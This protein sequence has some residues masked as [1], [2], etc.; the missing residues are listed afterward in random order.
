MM[1]LGDVNQQTIQKYHGI[2]LPQNGG[3]MNTKNVYSA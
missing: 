3:V 2:T 1:K